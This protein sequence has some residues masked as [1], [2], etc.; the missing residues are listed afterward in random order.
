MKLN[1]HYFFYKICTLFVLM[2]FPVFTSA[3]CYKITTTT[4]NPNSVYY[5]EP[6]K[7]TGK[8]WAGAR[9]DSGSMGTTPK[10]INVN[11]DLFQPPGTLVASGFVSI[12]EAGYETYD[13]EQILFRCTADE[14]GKLRE[15]Y[16]TNGDYLYAGNKLVNPALG[17]NDTYI[18]LARGLGMRI[19]NTI[20][21]EYYSRYWKSRPLTN[22]ER[23]SQGWILVK[24]KDFSNMEV[25]LFKINYERTA[26]IPPAQSSSGL[27]TF[28][29]QP[30]GYIAFQS[31]N[32]SYLLKDG[33]DHAS[34][35]HGFYAYWPAS[36]NMAR[37]IYIRN[38]STCF[39]RNVTPYVTFPLVTINELAEG[40]KVKLPIDI[41]FYCQLTPPASEGMSNLA[42]GTGAGQT[43]MG[44]LPRP[45]NVNKA[46][47]LGLTAPNGAGITHLVTDGYGTNP[48]MTKGV[49]VRIYR[50]SG[51]PLNFLSTLANEG[52]GDG[53]GWYPIY[54]D[55]RSVSF[56]NGV[57]ELTK[58]LYASLEALPREKITAGK[59][60]A[61]VQVIIQVQ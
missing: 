43:A 3:I 59:F 53:Y 36:V 28:I 16:S 35:Y 52:Q 30:A 40:K 60:N 56:N 29:N 37:R 46:I 55:A 49:G 19:K 18:S 8:N 38:A 48:N 32:F 21:G 25:E 41:D 26:D 27:I 13:P 61:T 22:L 23:D 57:A 34:N 2:L 54:D 1:C 33:S 6:G 50:P 14:E 5:T 20:T 24:A 45:A 39:V 31:S 12:L 10:V 11:N 4:T 51:V 47:E 9:D 44:F 58:T 7:G 17:L 42:S 15:F